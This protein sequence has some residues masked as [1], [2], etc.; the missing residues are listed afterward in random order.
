[1]RWFDRWFYRKWRWAWDN[2]DAPDILDGRKMGRVAV[3]QDNIVE[4]SPGWGDGLRMN[5]RKII[6]GYV[7]S[8]R[9]YDRRTDR[10]DDRHYMITDE[11]DF[12]TEL[13]KMI[14]M[15][16]MRQT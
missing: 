6:G 8:F 11:Q 16:S 13:G 3:P 2:R 10:S 4:E 9:I 7:V 12:N 1:M 15:E 14:T 5:V